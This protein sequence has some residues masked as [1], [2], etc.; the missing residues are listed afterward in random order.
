MLVGALFD[1]VDAQDGRLEPR[2]ALYQKI[3][4]VPQ[5]FA[6]HAGV[7]VHHGV[8][9]DGFAPDMVLR[10]ESGEPPEK[11]GVLGDPPRHAFE[12]QSG[13]VIGR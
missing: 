7:V 8:S 6:E 5:P 11:F 4:S 3:L 9:G 13:Q 12:I 10:E 1:G 2:T